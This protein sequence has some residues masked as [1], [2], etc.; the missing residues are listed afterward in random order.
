MRCFPMFSLAKILYKLK[1]F[2]NSL[3]TYNCAS[4]GKAVLGKCICEK[5][6]EKLSA[7][8]KYRNGFAFAYYYEGPAK[9]AVLYYKFG[10]DYEFCFDTLCDW[11]LLAF[12][13]L[14]EEKFDAVIPVPDYKTKDTRLSALS[15]KFA[16]MTDIP[17]RPELL[18]KIRQ[19]EKQHSLSAS[20]RRLNLLGAFEAD[21]SVAGKTVLLVDDIFTTGTTAAECSNAFYEKGAE[22]VCVLTVLKT[23]YN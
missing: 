21:D 14:E 20:E 12:E 10:N 9:D 19:T 16:L 11:L 18:K 7:V 22:K 3:F 1:R 8:E 13:K 2:G 6:S 17:F 15:K 4:C 5:C 23:K